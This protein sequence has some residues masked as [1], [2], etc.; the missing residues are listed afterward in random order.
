MLRLHDG[1]P[2]CEAMKR[3][4]QAYLDYCNGQSALL[5][6]DALP[7]GTGYPSGQGCLAEKVRKASDP[8][9]L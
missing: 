3:L 4:L 8:A 7:C 5:A 1:E 9:Q 6:R 2:N